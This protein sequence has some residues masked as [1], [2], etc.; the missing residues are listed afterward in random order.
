MVA[1]DTIKRFPRVCAIMPPANKYASDFPTPVGPS[2]T[3]MLSPSREG[4]SSSAC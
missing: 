3:A 2:I 4:A 1:L